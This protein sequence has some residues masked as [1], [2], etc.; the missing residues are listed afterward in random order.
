MDKRGLSTIVATLLIVLLV[1]IAVGLVWFVIRGTLESGAGQAGIGAKCLEL[2]MEATKVTCTAAGICDA[3]IHRSAGGDAIAGVKLVF[4][5][6]DNSF[7]HSIN[8]SITELQTK[9]ES[10][11]VTAIT[12][13]TKVDVVPY[14]EDESGNEQLCSAVSTFTDVTISG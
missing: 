6:G 5:N 8:E 9:T 11:V 2:N 3:T 1:I 12:N 13:V 7:T 4:S 10:D 14:F